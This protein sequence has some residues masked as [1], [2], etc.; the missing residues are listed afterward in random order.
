MRDRDEPFMAAVKDP[1]YVKAEHLMRVLRR[2]VRS[3]IEDFRKMNLPLSGGEFHV[4][5][6]GLLFAQLVY[7][8]LAS[9]GLTVETIPLTRNAGAAGTTSISSELRESFRAF[10]KTHAVLGLISATAHQKLH[11]GEWGEL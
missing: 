7:R 6:V 1:D 9:K 8:W 10:H 3:Q 4:H 5:H 2:A 11:G